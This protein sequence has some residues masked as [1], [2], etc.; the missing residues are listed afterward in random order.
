M[1][2]KVMTLEAILENLINLTR[3]TG[4]NDVHA[5]LKGNL[6]IWVRYYAGKKMFRLSIGRPKV[7]PSMQEW[8]TTLARWPW[9]V[10]AN[11]TKSQDEHA[12]SFFLSAH[13]PDRNA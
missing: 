8:N 12:L 11:P 5:K 1:S 9:R 4:E 13:I 3:D 2:E 6:H 10:I 7:A